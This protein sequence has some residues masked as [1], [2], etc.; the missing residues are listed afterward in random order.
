MHATEGSQNKTR[1]LRIYPPCMQVSSR[2]GLRAAFSA[3]PSTNLGR[4]YKF[5]F[6]D[7]M[8]QLLPNLVCFKLNIPHLD[9]QKMRPFED[10]D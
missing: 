1:H 5:S 2:Q 6:D 10:G 3:I 4:S 9:G 8:S 7:L